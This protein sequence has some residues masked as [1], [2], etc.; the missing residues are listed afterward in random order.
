MLWFNER[1]NFG[2]IST[3]D[4]ERLHVDGEGFARGERPKGRCAGQL[5]AF[6]VTEEAGTRKADAVR[7]VNDPAPRRARMRAGGR[8]KR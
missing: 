7:F 2:F 3:E 8:V 4:G 6:D 5:V 1:K